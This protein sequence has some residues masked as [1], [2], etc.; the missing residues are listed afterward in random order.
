MKKINLAIIVLNYQ[1]FSDTLEC[2]NS[3]F[4]KEHDN[5]DVFVVD[6]ASPNNSINF[7]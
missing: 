1:N 6:N 7:S 2:L 5:V 3:I 4:Q